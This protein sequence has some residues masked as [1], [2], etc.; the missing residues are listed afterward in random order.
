MKRILSLLFFLTVSFSIYSQSKLLKAASYLDVRSGKLVSPANLLIENGVIKSINPKEIPKNTEIINLG[1]KILL[2]GLMDMHVHLDGDFEGSW[3]YLRSESASDGT[4]RSIY[5]AE[6]TIMAGFTTVRNIGQVHITKDLID[7]AVQ[8][9][10]EKGWI[11][12]PRIIPSGHMISIQGGHADLTLGLSEDLVNVDPEYGIV[13]GKY[14]AIEAVRYQIK[15]GAKFIKMHATAGI[16]SLEESAGAQQLSN[17]EMKAIIEEAKRHHIK[18]AAHA[19]G[20]E[21]IKAAI[22]AGVYSIEH[23]SL[24]DAEAIELMKKRDVYLVPTVGL[25]E[26]MQPLIEKMP[27]RMQEKSNYIMP[28]AKQNIQSAIKAGVNIAMGSD[29]PLVPHGENAYEISAMVRLGMSNLD[30]IQSA[31]INPAKMLGLEDRGEIKEGLLADMIAVSA[32]PLKDITILEKVEFVM[33][34]GEVYKNEN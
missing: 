18:V 27:E 7:V 31:T 19:H 33:K 29:A 4:A 26:K 32:N 16:L 1:E 24:L 9:A 21:G 15:H 34:G 20:T 28:L 6:K 10:A 14:D 2:P 3:D 5:N 30:A 12:A 17:E 22:K 13:N 25:Q 11:K 8:A 23:G